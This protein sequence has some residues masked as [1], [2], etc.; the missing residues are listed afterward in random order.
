MCIDIIKEHFP[1]YYEDAT[2][3]MDTTYFIPCNI[4]VLKREMFIDWCEFVFGVLDIY[5]EKM[6]FKTDLD[7][8]NH[9]VN[10]MDKYVDTKGGIPNISTSYQSR[11]HSFL[12]ERLSSIFFKHNIKHPYNS[13]IVLT[14]V[15]YDFEKTYFYQYEG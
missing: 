13:N 9:V 14:E 5:N 11:I 15:H 2:L 4:F 12:M 6:G 10:N 7:V 1:E 8:C 3:L